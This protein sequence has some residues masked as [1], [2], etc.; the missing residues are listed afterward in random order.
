MASIARSFLAGT[1]ELG[2]EA[3]VFARIH[4]P[5]ATANVFIVIQVFY[6]ASNG[7][8]SRKSLTYSSTSGPPRKLKSARRVS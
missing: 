7:T 4:C 8:T 2:T 6:A 5:W 3:N 1:R